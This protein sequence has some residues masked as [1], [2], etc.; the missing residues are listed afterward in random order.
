MP[1]EVGHRTLAGTAQP[2]DPALGIP[3][4]LTPNLELAALPHATGTC[5]AR[6]EEMPYLGSPMT[7]R[8]RKEHTGG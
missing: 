7:Q 2:C 4:E 1:R 3:W 6:Q 5:P 8:Q